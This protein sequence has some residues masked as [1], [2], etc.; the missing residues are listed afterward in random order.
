M[1]AHLPEGL[2]PYK[3]TATFTDT[4]VPAAL[5]GDHSTKSGVW[6]L[7][8]VEAGAL[9]YLV[10][11]P[12]RTPTERILAPES[13]PGIV[14][15]TILHRVEPVGAVRFHVEFLHARNQAGAALPMHNDEA[16]SS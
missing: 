9:R 15:P 4:T 5:L 2:E 11:D 14:E 1:I 12:R 8:H 6:G 3:R 16:R 13:E 10:T 7:I